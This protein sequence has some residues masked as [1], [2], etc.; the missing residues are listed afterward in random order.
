MN[1]PLTIPRLPLAG[2]SGCRPCNRPTIGKT[3]PATLSGA[4]A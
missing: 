3:A 2:D 4:S 1:T